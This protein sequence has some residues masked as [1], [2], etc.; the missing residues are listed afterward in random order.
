VDQRVGEP[1]EVAAHGLQPLVVAGRR[2][3]LDGTQVGHHPHVGV[4]VDAVDER[5]EVLLGGVAVGHVPDHRAKG[6]GDEEGQGTDRGCLT[7]LHGDSRGARDGPGQAPGVARPPGGVDV[8]A[9]RRARERCAKMSRVSTREVPIRDESIKLVQFLKLADLVE[10]G[11]DAR[12][13]MIQGSVQVNGETETRRGRRLVKGDV[14]AL[15]GDSVR[16]T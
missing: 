15:G 9:V 12:P 7:A 11:A 10:N 5:G 14:V 3:V 16:V 4:G 8:N 2:A 13:L 6:E 1:V